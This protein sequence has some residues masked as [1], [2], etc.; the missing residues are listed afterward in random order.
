MRQKKEKEIK[1]NTRRVNEQQRH[2]SIGREKKRKICGETKPETC[3]ARPSRASLSST[4]L[5]LSPPVSPRAEGVIA[6]SFLSLL[7]GFYSI[8]LL[9]S[10]RKGKKIPIP[11]R[12]PPILGRAGAL[13]ATVVAPPPRPATGPLAVGPS[14]PGAASAG[15]QVRGFV[16]PFVSCRLTYATLVSAVLV[17]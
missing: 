3:V 1:K 15:A 6:L 5:S 13:G 12:N 11:L 9:A 8:P 10:L 14:G 16:A 2:I 7:P 4:S 17:G